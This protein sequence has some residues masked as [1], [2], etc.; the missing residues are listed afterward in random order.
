M[1]IKLSKKFSK[2]KKSIFTIGGERLDFCDIFLWKIKKK[3]KHK[4]GWGSFLMGEG[5]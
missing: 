3:K 1:A 4:K 2:K 5:L